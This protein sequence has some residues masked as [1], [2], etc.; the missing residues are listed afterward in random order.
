MD[1]GEEEEEDVKP[2]NKQ[3]LA[4]VRSATNLPLHVLISQPNGRPA[5]IEF[6]EVSGRTTA[7]VS[8]L[9]KMPNGVEIKPKITKGGKGSRSKKAQRS[10][11]VSPISRVLTISLDPVNGSLLISKEVESSELSG[12]ESDGG[13]D[14]VSEEAE[15]KR[16]ARMK[17]PPQVKVNH[18]VNPCCRI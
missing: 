14:V 10:D 4:L 3:F 17:R 13:N 8:E 18:F 1:S 5:T 12:K 2:K 16:T 7:F 11:T 9:Q 6:I 15:A